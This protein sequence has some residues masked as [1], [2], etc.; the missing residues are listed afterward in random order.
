MSRVIKCAI[1][2]LGRIG[3]TLEKDPLREKPASHAGAIF[4]HPRCE[5]AAGADP[6]VEQRNEFTKDWGVGAVYA[7]AAKMVETVRPDILHIASWTETH[8]DILTTA[9]ESKVPVVVCEKPLADN[10]RGV[11]DLIRLVERNETRIIMNHERRFSGDYRELKRIIDETELGDPLTVSARLYMGRRRPVEKT[12]Y[13]DGTHMLDV[14]RYLTGSDIRIDYVHGD[15][16]SEGGGLC[17]LAAAGDITVEWEIS[18]G[19]DHLVFELDWSFSSGRVRIGNGIFEV[20]KSVDSPFY[21]GF[22]SL[23]RIHNGW[24]GTTGYFTGMM[25]H[26]VLLFDHPEKTSLSSLSDGTA[27]LR[28]IKEILSYTVK[29]G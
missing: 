8:I 28:S 12:I 29:T 19:R 6:S 1:A 18:G 20:W 13:H 26:A 2:G 21:S 27:V 7:D 14:L 11:D 23:E 17:I 24:S 5:L 22:K 25:D 3:S 9:I 10:L 15:A 4:S 16:V